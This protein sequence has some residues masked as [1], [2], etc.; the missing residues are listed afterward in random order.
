[1]DSTRQNIAG[2]GILS[3][4]I[5]MACIS[6]NDMLV[7]QLSGG[8]PLHQIV[9]ARSGIGIM[10]SLLIVQYEGGWQILRTSHPW[11]HALRGL[12]IVVANMTFFVALSVL[13]LADVTA[14]FFVAPL[15]ITLLSIPMLGERVGPMRLG[16]VAFGFAGVVVMQRPWADA[17]DLEVSRIMLLLPVVAALTYALNQVMTRRL[18]VTSKASAM[19]VYIQAA[20][21]VVSV[22][23]FVVAGDGRL[24]QGSTNPS[25][26]FLLRAWVWPP[27]RDMWVFLGLGINV[28]IVGYCLSQA[29][30]LADAATVAPFEY[31]GLPL[32][33]FW[34]YVVFGEF[35]AFEV[36]VGIFMILGA[37]LFVFLRERHKSRMLG[38]AQPKRR[39]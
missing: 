29:Y 7:K 32:A 18:G 9:F 12:L 19:S 38:H 39:Y 28:A 33:V 37:G 34:G 1:M 27:A 3:V 2:L 13:P 16:A 22:G 14:L 30:R 6:V 35:P 20:F 24:A 21:I 10:L 4:L 36:W 26:L 15:F 17:G 5:G 8:Y 23:F 31:I 11:A 25:V